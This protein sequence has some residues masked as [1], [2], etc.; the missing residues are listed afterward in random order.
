MSPIRVAQIGVG[1]WGPN[2]LRNLVQNKSFRVTHV[3]E[4]SPDRRNYVHGQYPD[5]ELVETA[6]EVL[7]HPEIDAVVIATPAGTHYEFARRA[8][9]NG[10]HILVE[11]PLATTPENVEELGHMARTKSLTCMVG[12][13]FLY[14]NAVRYLKQLV[15]SGDLGQVRYVY[16]QRL[17]LGRVRSDVDALWN[18]A[19]HDVSILQYLFGDPTPLSVS[20]TG[21]SYVQNGIHDVVFMNIV[22]P[23]RVM[24]NVHVSWLDPFKTRRIVVVGS[25]RMVEYDDTAEHK[26]A[27]YDKGVDKM[28]VLGEHMD[29]DRTNVSFSYRTGEVTYPKLEIAE[30]LQVEVSH[31]A[32][33]IRHGTPCLTGPEH[34]LKITRIL[35]AS[36]E[37]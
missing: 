33:C 9:E 13:T 27:I 2:L 29:Y 35:C 25:D 3:G 15:D 37:Q 5:I 17:N 16:C 7:D 30:P 22:Y 11:K 20:K 36:N 4:S 14:N 34:A 6:E 19:P 18:L 23:N 28:A 31:F 24:A 8:L 10:K 21:M 32:D 12:H 26:I 1:Y